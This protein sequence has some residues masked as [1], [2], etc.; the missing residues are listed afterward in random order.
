MSNLQRYEIGLGG[1][2]DLQIT[3]VK[4]DDPCAE[5]VKSGDVAELEAEV[6]RLREF[7]DAQRDIWAVGVSN[8]TDAQIERLR[9]ARA[10]L[11]V[12]DELSTQ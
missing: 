10:A 12:S 8:A 5:W 2:G 9:V 3:P 1:F 6:E 7:Y 11:E 4:K